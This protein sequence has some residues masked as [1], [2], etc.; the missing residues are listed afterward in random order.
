MTPGEFIRA[1]S[2]AARVVVLLS[3]A[4]HVFGADQQLLALI[5]REPEAAVRFPDR[6][7]VDFSGFGSHVV[8]QKGRP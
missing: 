7:R 2:A 3:A 8:S 1:R 5:D 4:D 6:R